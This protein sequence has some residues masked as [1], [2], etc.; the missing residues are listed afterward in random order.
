MFLELKSPKNIVKNGLKLLIFNIVFTQPFLNLSNMVLTVLDVRGGKQTTEYNLFLIYLLQRSL[1]P[2]SELS[3][4]FLFLYQ[5]SWVES[6]QCLDN[7]DKNCKEHVRIYY[8]SLY[9]HL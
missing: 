2:V 6:N 9:S 7:Q 8:S 4:Q 3:L 1:Y 5:R